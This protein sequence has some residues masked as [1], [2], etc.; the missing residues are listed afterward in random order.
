[1]KKLLFLFTTLAL[2]CASYAQSSNDLMVSGGIDLLKTDNNELFD[3]AQLGFEANY[4]A[5][6][7]FTITAGVE[8]WTN[9]DESF[10]FGSR[11]YFTD[12]FFGRG[13]ALIGENDFSLGAG[14]ALVLKNNWRLELMGDFYFEGEFALRTGVAYVI[15]LR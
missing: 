10:V 12:N 3:K 9:R 14:G 4:F 6:R 1:M 11:Y 15:P 7:K 13:R 5:V 2:T 8:L